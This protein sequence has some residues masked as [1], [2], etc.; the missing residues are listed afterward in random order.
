MRV[1]VLVRDV[2]ADYF[3]RSLTSALP[4]IGDPESWVRNVLERVAS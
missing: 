3:E 1:L 4:P 2:I